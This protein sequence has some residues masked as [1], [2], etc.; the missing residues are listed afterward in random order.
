MVQ[1]LAQPTSNQ[2]DAAQGRYVFHSKG[3]LSSSSLLLA[4]EHIIGFPAFCTHT[5]K[6]NIYM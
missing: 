3:S 4:S 2:G 1:W 5:K 6:A